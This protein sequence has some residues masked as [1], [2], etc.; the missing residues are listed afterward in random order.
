M[1]A[2]TDAEDFS[3]GHIVLVNEAV[4]V[5]SFQTRGGS[6][7]SEAGNGDPH[8]LLTCLS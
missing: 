3:K 1:T 2:C 5:L 6:E 4:A 7:C 8:L